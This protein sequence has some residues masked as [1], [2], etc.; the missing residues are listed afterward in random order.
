MRFK[1]EGIVDGWLNGLPPM[2]QANAQGMVDYRDCVVQ[3]TTETKPLKVKMRTHMP[4]DP[5]AEAWERAAKREGIVPPDI[6]AKLPQAPAFEPER[7][8][9]TAPCMAVN[10]VSFIAERLKRLEAERAERVSK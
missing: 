5:W 1:E 10:D 3:I 6:A 9:Q 4:Q 2:A 7:P 8:K